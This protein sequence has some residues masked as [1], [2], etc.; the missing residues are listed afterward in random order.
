MKNSQL[1]L[2]KLL[3]K[4]Q[5]VFNSKIDTMENEIWRPV[6]GFEGLYEVSNY[7]RVKALYR[8]WITGKN[9]RRYKQEHIMVHFDLGRGYVATNLTKNGKQKLTY[10]HRIVATSFLPI[11]EG[12]IEVNHIDGVKSNNCL[13]NLEWCTPGENQKHAYRTGLK[14]KPFKP[15]KPVIQLTISGDVVKRWRSLK[16]LHS[17]G[18]DRSAVIRVAKGRQKTS[19]GF[20]WMY[21]AA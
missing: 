2:P 9:T 16:E 21:D 15:V 20:K 6:K 18:F 5:D 10:I 11:E 4:T 1:P 8:E 13:N 12:K 17:S 3:K 7:G 14:K 19:Y